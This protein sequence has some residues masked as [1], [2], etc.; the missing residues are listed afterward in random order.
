MSKSSARNLSLTKKENVVFASEQ[1]KIEAGINHMEG[2]MFY[3]DRNFN[4]IYFNTPFRSFIKNITD[5]DI[6]VGDS[7]VDYVPFF[8][9]IFRRE[10]QHYCRQAL[11]GNYLSMVEK[12]TY[13]EQNA[14]FRINISP[15]ILKGRIRG[16]SFIIYDIAHEIDEEAIEQKQNRELYFQTIVEEST[17]ITVAIDERGY[18]QYISPVISNYCVESDTQL[19][20]RNFFDALIFEEDFE[21]LSEKFE[22]ISKDPG[23]SYQLKLRIKGL[24]NEGVWL[25]AKITNLIRTGHMKCLICN[26]R[27][28]NEEIIFDKVM[29]PNAVP[30][31][32][33]ID[34]SADIFL[35]CDS[36]GKFIYGSPSV[37]QLLGYDEEQIK[38]QPIFSLV[39]PDSYDKAHVLLEK[40]IQKPGVPGN[41]V[42]ELLHR[43]GSKRWVEGHA[44][45][46]LHVPSIEAMLA[47]F[48][49][50]NRDT[51]LSKTLQ[52]DLL[53]YKEF[54]GQMVYPVLICEPNHF[55]I[56]DC[57]NA[58]LKHLEYG[59]KEIF[60]YP[61]L[62]ILPSEFHSRV[63]EIVRLK[64][65]LKNSNGKL[66]AT[67]QVTKSKK[68]VFADMY[69]NIIM[70][71]DAPLLCFIMMP[72]EK[73]SENIPAEMLHLTANKDIAS[74]K[75]VL[76][77]QEKER[78]E[79]GIELHDN[80]AQLISTL[81]LYLDCLSSEEAGKY[82]IDQ[83]LVK[84][85]HTTDMILSE[86]RKVSHCL[87]KSYSEDVGLKLSIEDL[88]DS[89][90]QAKTH[91]IIFDYNNVTES[92]LEQGLKI[93][94]FRIIQ[95]QLNNIIRHADA[96][97]IS[98]SVK[99]T[100]RIVTLQVTDDGR[101]SNQEEMMSNGVGLRNMRNRASMYNGDVITRSQYD[102]GRGFTLFVTFNLGPGRTDTHFK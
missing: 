75:S 84:A 64:S 81:K 73:E 10:W 20:G 33:I 76:E 101:G 93:T 88:L 80:V 50:V 56:I 28:L 22:E 6:V 68:V 39:H 49:Y 15:L 58:A 44:I 40:L 25:W 41:F 38:G 12:S 17:D 7:F 67:R 51:W 90:R 42:I 72:R 62:H 5:Q 63:Q 83:I 69:V 77:V 71:N 47:H 11:N 89:I 3:V 102:N 13:R 18:I 1:E 91:K 92:D 100:N 2:L 37:K 61:I 32:S 35:M 29:D 96:Q 19:R 97:T 85:N 8:G 4:F 43:D 74:L 31:K 86:I 21:S 14:Y 57:N 26:L 34:H 66:I 45:N 79:I 95:E 23:G 60:H 48:K 52:E 46:L 53:T 87:I 98:V 30:F 65:K 36:Q 99:Q 27:D 59:D 9:D 82:D 24:E 78:E 94:I 54:F 16:L 55:K 70:M